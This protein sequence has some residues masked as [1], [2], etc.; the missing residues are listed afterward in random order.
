MGLEIDFK[1]WSIA[2]K[3]LPRDRGSQQ[4]EEKWPD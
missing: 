2:V 4:A 3:G 1:L